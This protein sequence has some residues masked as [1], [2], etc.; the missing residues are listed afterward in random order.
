[1]INGFAKALGKPIPYTIAPRRPGDIDTCYADTRLAKEYLG[2]EATK[3]LDDMCKD[4]L[5]WQ[6]KNPDGY[7]D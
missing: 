6:M 5:N 3:T 2:F 7:P 4:Q 1:M